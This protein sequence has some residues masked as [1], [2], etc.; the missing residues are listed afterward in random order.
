MNKDNASEKASHAGSD[1]A[2]KTLYV[3]D[4]DGTLMRN[5]ETLSSYTVQTINELIEKGL[6]FTYATARSIESARPIAGGLNLRLPA[7]TRN[8]AVLADN[9]TGQH[10]EKAVFTEAEVELLKKMLPE[11]PKYGFVSCFL[12]EVMHRLYIDCE[13]TPALQGYFDYY[14]SNPTVRPVEA[15]SDLF[16]GETGYVTL[17]GTKEE[18]RP[19]YE[20]VREYKGWETLFQ[21]DT[22]RA[23]YWLEICPQNCTKAKT[24]RKVKER[25]GFDRLVVFGDGINDIPMFEIADE[26]YAV[27][28]ALPELKQHATGMIGCNEE[29]AVA[30]YLKGRMEENRT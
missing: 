18:I 29:D 27:S 6:A 5:D 20:R 22:Y 21:K 9:A 1:A 24:I 11:L 2:G 25:Y 16:S 3:T 26:A 30:N 17:I 4:L 12:G 10:L 8:G 14:E 28:N 7:I 19:I 23:E 13:H 15:F